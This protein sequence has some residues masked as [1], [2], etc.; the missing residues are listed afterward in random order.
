MVSFSANLAVGERFQS[1]R[2]GRHIQ[3]R[4]WLTAFLQGMDAA[5]GAEIGRGEARVGGV[6][7][8]TWMR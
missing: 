8:P 1:G 5:A 6:D 3:G 2:V 7:P 4:R